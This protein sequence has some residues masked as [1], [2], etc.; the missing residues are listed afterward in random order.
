MNETMRKVQI[1]TLEIKS[2]V[3]PHGLI[4]WLELPLV[5]ALVVDAPL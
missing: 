2:V 4:D 3:I 1:R 5:D